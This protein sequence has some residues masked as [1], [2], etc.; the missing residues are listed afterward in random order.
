ML[1]N[2]DKH[3]QFEGLSMQKL[4]CTDRGKMS[5][6]D[7]FSTYSKEMEQE[8]AVW[9]CFSVSMNDVHFVL[10]QGE[11]PAWFSVV[12]SKL[13]PVHITT[14]SS[15]DVM[16]EKHAG[17]EF[18]KVREAGAVMSFW[19]TVP[20]GDTYLPFY[21]FDLTIAI[22]W[23]STSRLGT[24]VSC[25]CPGSNFP[26]HTGCT[27][28]WRNPQEG[29]WLE[30]T[31]GSCSTHSIFAHSWAVGFTGL[32]CSGCDPSSALCKLEVAP[33]RIYKPALCYLDNK[34]LISLCIALQCNVGVLKHL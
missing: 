20:P 10:F 2:A 33:L 5:V 15:A 24:G 23:H 26:A 25:P 21:Y 31:A 28:K 18:F 9:G 6:K 19:W 3:F 11:K 34:S 7:R 22:D 27:Y 32:G 14:L 29:S 8:R 12:A 30:P 13:L 17:Q 1:L 4:L 16:Y